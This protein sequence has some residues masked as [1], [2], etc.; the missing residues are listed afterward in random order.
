[1]KCY[2]KARGKNDYRFFLI[3]ILFNCY[4]LNYYWADLLKTIELA[5]YVK[6]TCDLKST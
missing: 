1:M 2:S 5:W 3:I 4:S 6:S